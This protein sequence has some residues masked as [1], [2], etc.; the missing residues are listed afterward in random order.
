M[1]LNWEKNVGLHGLYKIYQRFKGQGARSK[2]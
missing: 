1:L 2:P